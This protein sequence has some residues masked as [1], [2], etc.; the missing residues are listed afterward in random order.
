GVAMLAT[1]L[2]IRSTLM[3]A[4]LETEVA[5]VG[6]ALNTETRRS[7]QAQSDLVEMENETYFK[8]LI[9]ADEAWEHNEPD[10][11]D[12]FL[13]WCP[14]R[15]RRW[16]WHHLR[17][18]FHSEL[19]TLQGHSGS[20]CGASFKP[21][22]TEVACLSEAGGFLLWETGSDQAVRRIPI[23]DGSVYGLAF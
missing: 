19:R 3:S 11:A 22:G 5:R 1:T 14:V 9:A 4:R 23:Y 20:F 10:R 2:A 13:E 6:M 7:V 8:Q 21:D 18:R 17:R 12:Q 16:E 15:L